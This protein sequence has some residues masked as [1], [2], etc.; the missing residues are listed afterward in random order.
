MGDGRTTEPYYDC[1]QFV[2]EA[3]PRFPWID[4]NRLGVTGGSYGGYMTNYIAA[5]SKRFKAYISSEVLLTIRSHMPAL[6][7]PAAAQALI[8]S[9]SL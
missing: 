8:L 6:T 2:D 4:E 7:K 9:L 3:I 1:L 5:H